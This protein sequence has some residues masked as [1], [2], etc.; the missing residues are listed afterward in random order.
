MRGTG[1]DGV[2]AMRLR[3]RHKV[4]YGVGY[5]SVALTTDMT[6]TWLLKCYRPDPQDFRW[7]VLASAGAFALAMMVGQMMNAIADP[8]VGF[9]S[10]RVKSR[11]GR[12][13]PFILIGAPV[14]ALMF[15]LI[16][17]PPTPT[18]S[19]LNAAYLAV[20]ISLFF[21]A[22]TIVVCPYLA[23]LPEI[24]P[25]SGERVALTAW[26]GGFNVLGAVGGSL[27]A[28][29][30]IDHYGYRTMAL[31]F[32]PVVL[33]CSLAPLFVPAQPAAAG[34][35]AERSDLPLRQ[36]F[37][38][39]LRNPFF[40]PYVI[41]QLFFWM[42]LRIIVGT[43]PKLVEIR[44]GVPETGQGIVMATGLLVAAL[45]FPFMPGFARRLGKKRLLGG[46][47]VYFGLMMVPLIF[48]GRLPLPLSPFGQSIL[49]MAC[50]GPAIAALFTL[51]NAMVADIVDRDEERT[52]QRREA[53]Y[54]GVQGFILK[55]GM[56][57]GIALAALLLDHFGETATRQ[58]GFTACALTAMAFAWLAAGALSR[59][60]GN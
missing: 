52:G 1:R 49:I 22:F 18:I 14:L 39:T 40:V 42:A 27:G 15:S 35:S 11:W 38:A 16:W 21:V 54:F 25:A 26:Q 12:R 53:I 5:L 34:S 57:V 17:T 33:V 44:A 48:L 55:T 37:L 41:A 59:Y 31:C 8:L 23:M 46:A 51:P 30:L 20:T 13:K 29:Y 58:G 56:G 60:R 9:W 24:A 45:F 7:T 19:A 36:A 10:D 32:A 4:L 43:L 50:A 6:L 47:M 28:G 3:T 2:A